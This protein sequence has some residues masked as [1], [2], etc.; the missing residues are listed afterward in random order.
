MGLA[1]VRIRLL[2]TRKKYRLPPY[3]EFIAYWRRQILNQ[4][5]GEWGRLRGGKPWM[6]RWS[7]LPTEK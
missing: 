3:M 1:A 5:L 4:K 7:P 2:A 6:L